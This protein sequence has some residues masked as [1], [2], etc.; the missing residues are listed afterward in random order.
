[1]KRLNGYSVGIV[2]SQSG[3]I[4][5]I[6]SGGY[7]LLKDKSKFAIRL[8]NRNSFNC[9][10][11]LIL[12][13]TVQGTWR[14]S[15]GQSIRVERGA[16]DTGHFTFYKLGSVESQL[17]GI[18][19]NGDEGLVEV[20]FIPEKNRR[21]IWESDIERITAYGS[22]SLETP[23]SFSSPTRSRS[24]SAGGV[25]LSGSS[26]QKFIE[27]DSID[28]DYDNETI[29][30]LRLACIENDETPRPLPTSN[31]TPIPPSLTNPVL[32]KSQ[33]RKYCEFKLSEITKETILN[34]LKQLEEMNRIDVDNLT[35]NDFKKV[36]DY[37][38]EGW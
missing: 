27:A 3:S 18:K 13:G 32:S 17:A 9:D 38:Y 34:S 28:L 23:T 36:Q 11:K 29:I 1:M 14:L 19:A 26:S 5:E 7:A 10:A 35:I 15:P 30:R 21:N 25:G 33:F 2:D 8:E 37:I 24:I 16:N 31:S 20:V 6:I 22:K 12:N 4:A